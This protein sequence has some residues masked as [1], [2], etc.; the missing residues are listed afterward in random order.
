MLKWMEI[1][2]EITDIPLSYSEE[3]ADEVVME[4]E[5][6]PREGWTKRHSFQNVAGVVR[7]LS[8]DTQ[9]EIELMELS[10]QLHEAMKEH[11]G[12]DLK[13]YTIRIDE[14]GKATA[15][16]EYHDPQPADAN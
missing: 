8:I 15:K 10:F 3:P 12:G 13:K 1:V 5:L 4:V 14:S 16:F 11:T 2:K 7:D 9:D 6:D